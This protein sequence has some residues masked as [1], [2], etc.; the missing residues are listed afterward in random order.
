MKNKKKLFTIIFMVLII[1]CFLYL[2]ARAT[3]TS[4]ESEIDG[5]VS[6][7]VAG[8]HFKI[9][10]VD[11]V[12]NN[13]GTLDNRVILDNTTW[14]ST[15]TREEKI[16]PG[17]SGTIDLELDPSG[18]EVAILY[19][20]RFVDKK[21]DD[22]TLLTFGNITSTDTLIRTGVDTYTG[23]ITLNDINQ[24]R[25]VTLS[26]DFYFDYL[27]DIEGITEDNQSLDDLFEIHFHAIQYR[28]EEIEEY[29]EE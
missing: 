24:S 2:G 12:A 22:D 27:T 9:N 25:T 19:E 14:V 1:S 10:G 11:V 18:S 17:S 7:R 29:E 15:H 8:I 3:Y 20:F 26:A 28:G 13:D 4:Y 16:S 6:N 5:N 23:V 21:I